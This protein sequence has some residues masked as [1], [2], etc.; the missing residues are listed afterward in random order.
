MQR[1]QTNQCSCTY[2]NIPI[3]RKNTHLL[4]PFCLHPTADLEERVWISLRL[5]VARLVR[6][7]GYLAVQPLPLGVGGPAGVQF[8]GSV[9]DHLKPV[10]NLVFVGIE[11]SLMSVAF[12]QSKSRI[13]FIGLK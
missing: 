9:V 7:P 10:E 12:L 5:V 1:N 4:T 6:V 3:L 13:I 11:P 8:L 2:S